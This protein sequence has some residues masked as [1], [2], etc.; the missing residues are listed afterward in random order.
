MLIFPAHMETK[1]MSLSLWSLLEI[2]FV[3]GVRLMTRSGSLFSKGRLT[4]GAN[5]VLILDQLNSR[6]KKSVLVQFKE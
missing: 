6:E 2:E 4:Y 5:S 3:P 1:I